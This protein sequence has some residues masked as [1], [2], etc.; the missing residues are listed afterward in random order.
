[1]SLRERA[2]QS[3]LL[4]AYS[5]SLREN[6]YGRTDFIEEVD[7]EQEEAE[8]EWNLLEAERDYETSDEQEAYLKF[9]E[10]LGINALDSAVL[11]DVPAGKAVDYQASNDCL[12]LERTQEDQNNRAVLEGYL[13][14]WKPP[15]DLA[16]ANGFPM[17]TRVRQRLDKAGI[18]VA[19]YSPNRNDDGEGVQKLDGEYVVVD[20]L[21]TE[22]F[23]TGYLKSETEASA[24][25][26]AE[27]GAQVGLDL[28]E[29]EV[30]RSLMKSEYAH[31]LSQDDF[32]IDDPANELFGF[33]SGIEALLEDQ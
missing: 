12:N 28:D 33:G 3:E 32:R 21:D 31:P 11:A 9:A 1:M 20:E 23:A 30:R 15:E 17:V 25:E 19:D 14:E 6:D 29:E 5:R 22:D 2:S 18:E 10:N 27:A 8:L 4:E 24:E 16:L 13:K 7:L 26:V